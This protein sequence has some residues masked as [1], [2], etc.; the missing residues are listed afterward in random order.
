MREI[1]INE[2]RPL[3]TW[4]VRV[5]LAPILLL[6][7]VAVAV[8]PP[9]AVGGLYLARN[10]DYI[11]TASVVAGS[12]L[13][14]ARE[15]VVLTAAHCLTRELERDDETGEAGFLLSFDGRTFHEVAPYRLGDVRLGYDLA[16]LVFRGAV[17]QVTPLRMGS[18]DDIDYGSEVRNFANPLGM[19]LQYFTGTVTMLRLEASASVP[20]SRDRW[21][22]NA[23]AALQVGPGSSGSL[24][25]NSD[26]EYIGVLSSVI[27]PRFGSPFTVFVPLWKI[28]AFLS[29]EDVAR[30]VACRGCATAAAPLV[31]YSAQALTR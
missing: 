18:W 22:H 24:I 11:C 19:G 3:R 20:E 30:E 15:R 4:Y 31:S 6:A 28:A 5:A 21:L 12:E 25:L 9:D 27:D 13:G 10:G 8:P 14:L 16:V 2:P 7:A 29:G 17:P 1:R 26:L 23:V